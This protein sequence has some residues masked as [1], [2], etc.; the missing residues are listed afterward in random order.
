MSQGNSRSSRKQTLDLV[1][2][3]SLFP[4]EPANTFRKPVQVVHSI[5]R[6]D[7]TLV[8]RKCMNTWLKNAIENEADKDGW[9]SMSEADFRIAIGYESRNHQHLKES[10]RDLMGVVFEWDV[11]P[12]ISLGNGTT[13]HGTDWEASVL[14][15][16]TRKVNG[17]VQYKIND[18][19]KD[20]IL[21]PEVYAI[22]DQN[23]GRR[24]TTASA[25]VLYEHCV[26]FVNV[27]KTTPTT[28]QL[29]RNMMVGSDNESYEEFKIFNNRVLKSSIDEV[30]RA[31]D[32]R[33]KEIRKRSGRVIDTIQFEV[34][35]VQ[36]EDRWQPESIDEM[37]M[38]GTIIAFGVPRTEARKITRVYSHERVQAA[39]EYV[40][41]RLASKHGEA[42]TNT[43]AYFRAALKNDYAGKGDGAPAAKPS[44]PKAAPA[45]VSSDGLSPLEKAFQ[46]E[47]MT[48]AEKYFNELDADAKRNFIEQYN[49]QQPTKSLQVAN[50][51]PKVAARAAFF[52]W[53]ANLTWGPATDKELL[54]FA[55]SRG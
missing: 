6:A 46:V 13:L 41:A 34:A 22:V 29:L 52:V 5:A 31:T 33:I 15:P 2:Q 11:L 32:I 16:N 20:K 7:M 38:V 30:N 42:I 45:K 51:K 19:L 55:K 4:D 25:L 28:W 48:E 50:S 47:R 43:G 23:I 12:K 44:A 35:K 40:S 3:G 24:F 26:R 1:M 17:F 54:E 21:R 27:G 53:L 10:I 49:A 36:Q 37:Q 18:V 8:Q 9:Y 14:F 39:I